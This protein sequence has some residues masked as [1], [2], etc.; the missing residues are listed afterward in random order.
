MWA[1]ADVCDFVKERITCNRAGRVCYEDLP[2][3]FERRERD[4]VL[5]WFDD[6]AKMTNTCRNLRDLRRVY[7]DGLR[8][9]NWAS[10][11]LFAK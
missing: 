9:D 11:F 6:R 3:D 1:R 4:V 10:F 2:T 7:V 8:R 5:I